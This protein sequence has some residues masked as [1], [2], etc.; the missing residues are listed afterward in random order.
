MEFSIN[1]YVCSLGYYT[2]VCPP[3]S[4]YRCC[5]PTCTYCLFWPW[6][7]IISLYFV[8]VCYELISLLW[9]SDIRLNQAFFH[10]YFAF[11]YFII[12]THFTD[13][14]HKI[15]LTN[16]IY[17]HNTKNVELENK[18]ISGWH[19]RKARLWNALNNRAPF[20]RG[21]KTGWHFSEG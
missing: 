21:V 2:L 7:L 19:I 5:R 9:Q 15:C 14:I 3:F 8:T 6:M 4:V 20:P 11:F 17:P 18:K 10:L 16:S 12:A 1:K 13:S